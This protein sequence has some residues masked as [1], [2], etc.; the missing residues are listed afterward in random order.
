[1]S[2]HQNGRGLATGQASDGSPA[3]GLADLPVRQIMSTDIMVVDTEDDVLLAWEIMTRAGVHHLPV[4]DGPRLVGMLD[5]RTL[6]REWPVGAPRRRLHSVAEVVG[7]R[8]PRVQLDATVRSA[9]VQMAA[10]RL[11]AVCVVDGGGQLAGVLTT[12]DLVE[13]LAGI[14]QPAEPEPGLARTPALFRLMPVTPSR[15]PAGTRRR[16]SR[17]GGP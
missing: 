15:P 5:D 14:R 13:A 4:M 11:E 3:G 6:A 16:P 17:Q 8:P 1:M 2:D 10:G 9:A 7:G 12:T